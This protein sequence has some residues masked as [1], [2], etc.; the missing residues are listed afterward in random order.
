MHWFI[1]RYY[2]VRNVHCTEQL[3]Q[4]ENRAAQSISG[5][6]GRLLGDPSSPPP[7]PNRHPRRQ[8]FHF[9]PYY[10]VF[11]Y[12]ILPKNQKYLARKMTGHPPPPNNCPSPQSNWGPPN[13]PLC[14]TPFWAALL[15]T[16]FFSASSMDLLSRL[17]L[18]WVSW[19]LS[20]S[21]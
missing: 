11:W 9:F 10:M 16:T 18:L 14:S 21:L 5:A 3:R 8:L 6:Q 20:Y 2:F 7:P 4:L 13:C 1:C 17:S 12:G 15:V 19:S